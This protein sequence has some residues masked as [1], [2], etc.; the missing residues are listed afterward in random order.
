MVVRGGG[1]PSGTSSPARREKSFRSH[2]FIW[3][4]TTYEGERR[5]EEEEK[6]TS[7]ICK[8]DREVFFVSAIND[9][10]NMPILTV[11]LSCT[12]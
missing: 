7:I 12:T 6:D 1:V 2:S 9:M 8:Y 11:S 10:A 4:T 3:F 5:E